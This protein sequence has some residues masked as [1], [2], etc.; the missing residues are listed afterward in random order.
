MA[1][2]LSFQGILYHFLFFIFSTQA[3]LCEYW[4]SFLVSHIYHLPSITDYFSFTF[5][6]VLHDFLQHIHLY[7]GLHACL[8]VCM[9]VCMW[10]LGKIVM[11]RVYLKYCLAIKEDIL[12]FTLRIHLSSVGI[13]YKTKTNWPIFAKTFANASDYLSFTLFTSTISSDWEAG[14]ETVEMTLW[15]DYF[16]AFP[17]AILLLICLWSQS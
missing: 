13:Y 1:R 3:R 17:F 10:Y 2:R 12:N 14:T 4:I 8:Y 11:G 6:F 16:L 7:P 15:H 9:F 5:L